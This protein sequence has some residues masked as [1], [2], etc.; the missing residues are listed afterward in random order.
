MIW[1][2]PQQA[3]YGP[4]NTTLPISVGFEFSLSSQKSNT[5]TIAFER[6]KRLIFP[7]ASDSS[8]GLN[9]LDVTVETVDESHPTLA[10][11][12]SYTLK[13][14]ADGA[15]LHANTIYGALR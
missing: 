9:R 2:Y 13:V 5:L 4:L 3:T 1:P 11:D 14:S 7:H 12:E 10:T 8:S 6:Y 15:N